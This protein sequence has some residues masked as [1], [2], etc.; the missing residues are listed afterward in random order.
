[1]NSRR[2]IDSISNK[3]VIK[4]PNGKESQKFIFDYKTRTIQHVDTK[5]SLDIR[6][7]ARVTSESPNSY[8]YQLFRYNTNGQLVNQK[9]KVLEVVG[10]NDS[11][12]ATL[13]NADSNKE[14]K[15][16]WN[17]VYVDSIKKPNV[18]PGGKDEGRGLYHKRPFYIVSKMWMGRVISV[19]GGKNLV[20]QSRND[21]AKTQQWSYDQVS[22]TIRSV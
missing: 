9:G 1:M 13:G 3:P 21:N 2:Y 16:K 10:A 17:I 12:G 22:K 4:T 11:E 7:G 19:A 14:Q 5:R 8:W 15:Q 18:K 20:I 6:S